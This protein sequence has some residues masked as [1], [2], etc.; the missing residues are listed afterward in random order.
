M[1]FVIN[2]RFLTQ[3]ITGVQRFAIEISKELIKLDAQVRF[4]TPA[5][6]VHRDIAN[7][8]GAVEIGLLS[9]HLWEQITL[10]KY[11]KRLGNPLLVNL[12]NTAP[13]NYSN[14]IVTI[15][16]INFKLFPENF[17]LPFRTYYNYMIPRIIQLS[18]KV[19]TVSK[20]SKS[21]IMK[22]YNV[23]CNKIKVVY[24]AASEVFKPVRKENSEKYILA[25][26]SLIKKKNLGFLAQAFCKLNEKDIKLYIVGKKNRNLKN[27]NPR[28][29]ENNSKIIFQGR[30]SDK[31]LAELYSN[32]ICFVFPS[33]YEGFGLPPL[34]AQACGC[35]AIVSDVASLPEV[36]GDSVLYCNP[37]NVDDLTKCINYYTNNKTDRLAFINKGFEN[38]KRY[39]WTDSSNSLAV[40]I[41]AMN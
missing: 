40:L 12:C 13:L 2:A 7:E 22:H 18:K 35:P 3:P 8:L 15:H 21:E 11:L 33:L 5:N 9:G 10:P 19:I 27:I 41:R 14:K 1:N 31:K 28:R 20:F 17:S 29:L 26:S 23:D 6:I 30:V 34:E 32:A 16:D 25:V 4:I 24:N 37:T 38:N 39:S 36:F